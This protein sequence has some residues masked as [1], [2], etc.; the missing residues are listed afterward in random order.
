MYHRRQVRVEYGGGGGVRVGSPEET[1]HVPLPAGGGVCVR[2]R[3]C[4]CT[5]M[6]VFTCLLDY[7]SDTSSPMITV[8]PGLSPALIQY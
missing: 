1:H 4:A 6:C 3:V 2:V 7:L 8:D 5:W